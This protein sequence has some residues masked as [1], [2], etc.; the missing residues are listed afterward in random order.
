[1]VRQLHRAKAKVIDSDA[2]PPA[3]PC[4]E[5]AARWPRIA[6]KL[7]R[8]SHPMVI[9]GEACATHIMC[10]WYAGVGW[11]IT[12]TP[13]TYVHPA[14]RWTVPR[15]GQAVRGGKHIARGYISIFEGI[16]D[17]ARDALLFASIFTGELH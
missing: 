10:C 15:S 14:G 16:L 2:N 3:D 7:D 8:T 13:W 17:V 6:W 4:A 9:V 1:M 5:L 12:V 11:Q